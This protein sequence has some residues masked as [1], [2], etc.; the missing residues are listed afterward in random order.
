MGADPVRGWRVMTVVV[1]EDRPP[2]APAVVG[3]GTTP[4]IVPLPAVDGGPSSVLG[5]PEVAG[6]PATVVVVVGAAVV[7]VAG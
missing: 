2:A 5:G 3:V 7:V 1:V 6:P 4:G